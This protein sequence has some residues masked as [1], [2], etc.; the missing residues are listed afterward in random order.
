MPMKLVYVSGIALMISACAPNS[1][2]VEAQR[3]R[4]ADGAKVEMRD[5][6][7]KTVGTLT[8][9]PH[10]NGGVRFTGRLTDVPPGVHGI[11]IHEFGK[12]DAPDFK[13]AGAH[14]SPSGKQHGKF[15]PQG[16][17]EGD[18]GNVR[19]DPNGSAEVSMINEGVTLAAGPNSLLKPGGT[20]LV[21]HAD[22]D[23]LKTD[24]SGNSGDRIAC[25]IIVRAQ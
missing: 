8:I 25:G 19:I 17:H 2:S 11:H 4:L 23:D 7:G 10:S 3:A 15:N 5:G 13:S 9:A 14:F 20:S 21:L 22:P 18:I 16:W 24:P 6:H 12:C 1:P